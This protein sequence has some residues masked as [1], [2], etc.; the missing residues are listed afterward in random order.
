MELINTYNV[1]FEACT[2]KDVLRA[3]EVRI[4]SDSEEKI[5]RVSERIIANSCLMST[6]KVNAVSTDSISLEI[7]NRSDIS[8]KIIDLEKKI[9]SL[10]E[11]QSKHQDELNDL[12]VQSEKPDDYETKV[13]ELS[14]KIIQLRNE[15]KDAKFQLHG[16]IY[17]VYKN[18]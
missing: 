1:V 2:G 6:A 7:A 16:N 10:K 18:S 9:D 3:P 11:E 17:E 14:N 5:I 12:T 15:I 4:T 13:R 8:A